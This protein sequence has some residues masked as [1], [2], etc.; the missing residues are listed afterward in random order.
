MHYFEIPLYT[1]I[2]A[3][4]FL[5]IFVD[6]FVDK[7]VFLSF[8]DKKI[9]PTK[10]TP[11]S[12]RSH[13]PGRLGKEDPFPVS[14]SIALAALS[15]AAHSAPPFTKCSR[16]AYPLLHSIDN[17]DAGGEA[18][19]IVVDEALLRCLPSEISAYCCCTSFLLNR[20]NFFV[21]TVATY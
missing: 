13:G 17:F 18:V 20:Y 3:F 5:L 19:G 8:I 1:C 11:L 4:I 9:L 2:I 10:I 12:R 16:S 15:R 21:F 14:R 6:K 7:K